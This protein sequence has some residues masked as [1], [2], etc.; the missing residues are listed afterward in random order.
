MEETSINIRVMEL[1]AGVGGFRVGLENANKDL[2]SDAFKVIWSNQWDPDLKRQYAND[3]YIRHWGEEGHSSI[4]IA[5][6]E[7]KDIPTAD[8]LVAGF[9]CQDYSVA[10]GFKGKGIEGKKG[11]LWW[12]LAKIIEAKRPDYLLLEN[13]DRLL[14]SPNG[15]KGRDFAI[16]LAKLNDLGY[17]VEWRVIN[18]ADYGFPQKRKR[19]FIFGFKDTTS[20]STICQEN[21][22][23]WLLSNSIFAKAF[24]HEES[25]KLN[26]Q[27]NKFQLIG[28]IA[29]ISDSFG[30]GSKYKIFLNSGFAFNREVHQIK[31]TH[32]YTGERKVLRNAIENGEVPE[33]YF[34]EEEHIAQWKKVKAAKKLKRKSKHG[35]EYEY[36]EGAISYPDSQ[37]KP[38]RTIVTSEGG[39][40]PERMKHIIETDEGKLRRLTPVELE[41]LNGFPDNHTLIEGISPSRRAY[42]MGN[43]LVTGIIQ[44]F[45]Y[46]LINELKNKP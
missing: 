7:L 10:T 46:S 18:A 2:E 41:R 23:N 39:K 40:S 16:M 1:F 37:D 19:V 17:A 25:A 11:V 29:N 24:P 30:K 45:G 13:V 44:K 28:E 3:I 43:A 22:K 12:E 8:L 38:A 20:L 14:G 33:E 4:D 6:V 9:P 42:L 36:A 15:Q 21:A 26:G 27:V 34:I 31:S 32:T 35:F 5:K